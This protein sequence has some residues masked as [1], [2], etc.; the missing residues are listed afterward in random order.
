MDTPTEITTVTGMTITA[1]D[2]PA[3]RL[4]LPLGDC[5]VIVMKEKFG[6][7]RQSG[8]SA[9]ECGHLEL[10]VIELI[11]NAISLRACSPVA[12]R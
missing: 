7:D 1:G 3:G 6:R 2:K 9:L 12:D 11:P 10:L 8:S 5:I 4:T